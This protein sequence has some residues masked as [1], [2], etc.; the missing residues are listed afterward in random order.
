MRVDA[1]DAVLEAELL[2]FEVAAGLEKLADDAHGL[3][4]IAL[5]EEHAPALIAEGVREGGARD[6]GSDDDH[7]PLRGSQGRVGSFR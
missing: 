1:V 3:G 6:A 7:V 4:E 2:E 5:E